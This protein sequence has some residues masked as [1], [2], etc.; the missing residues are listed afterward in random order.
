MLKSDFYG[1]RGHHL[2]ASNALSNR[3]IARAAGVVV[4]G[5]LASGILGLV[6]T[7][8]VTAIFGTG[9]ASDAF[10]AAQRIPELVFTLVAGGALGSS[11]IP[12]FARR[13]RTSD[14]AGAWRLASA[15]IT[16]SSLAA[17][18][19]SLLLVIFAPQFVSVVLAPA[20][21][22]EVQALTTS[23]TRIM[24]LTPFIFSISGLL[25][26]ILQA[27]GNFLLPSLAISM[28][29]IGLIVG[30]LVLAYVIPAQP[31]DIAQVGNANVYG[32]A[33]GAVLSALLHL[34]IQ[35]P[36][37]L[38][39]ARKSGLSFPLR[40][41][42]DWRIPGVREVMGLMG[43]RVLGLGVAQ[44]NFIVNAYLASPMIDG[45]YTAL[46]TAWTL[47][48]FVLGT[49]G[50]SIGTALFPSLAALAA[51]NDMDGFKDRLAS[52]L[53]AV[54]FLAIPSTFGLIVLG[55]MLIALAFQRGEFTVTSVE[56]TAWALMFFAV[57]IAG[58]SGLEVLSRAFYALSDTLTPVLIGVASLVANIILSLILV[59]F[60]GDPT[61]L[62]RGPFA[63]LALANS[64]TT[65]LEALVLWWLLRRRIGGINDARIWG[66]VWR[67]LAASVLMTG[68]ILL[69]IGL[70]P[71]DLPRAGFTLIGIAL[72][73]GIFLGVSIALGMDEPRTVFGAIL[74]RFR[75]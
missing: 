73:G 24:M 20:D 63:G 22:P 4:V 59:N 42:P 43:P 28:N 55:R 10:A 36:G 44:L 74:R 11:F 19:L 27:H 15:V 61:S 40:F 65:L 60:I 49:I 32:L 75:R 50:Q 57:G 58:H 52:A 39:I 72:G 53:R 45:S 1:S 21:P 70:A 3:Q 17:G 41:V 64:V 33:W 56:A 62:E 31:G 9:T 51:E 2:S 8:V 25:M 66:G 23:L 38:R 69:Y 48:F 7:G 34:V 67:T 47:M 14:E 12:V 26:G 71:E 18:L 46:V 29:N 16:L 6:R 54:L 37:L 13:L 30:A 5:F 68:A 35:L